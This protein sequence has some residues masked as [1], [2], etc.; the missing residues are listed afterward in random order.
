V[1]IEGTVVKGSQTGHINYK[2][3]VPRAAKNYPAIATYTVGTINVKLDQRLQERGADFWT[4]KDFTWKPDPRTGFSEVNRREGFGFIQTKFEFGSQIYDGWA[5]LPQGHPWSYTGEGI[6]ILADRE[7]QG[8][9]YD[10]RCAIH[11]D[12]PPKVPRPVW[13]VPPWA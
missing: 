7:I 4:S 5:V 2:D 9:E 10:K 6:E 1:K 11:F 3:V 8:V 13:F 12:Q